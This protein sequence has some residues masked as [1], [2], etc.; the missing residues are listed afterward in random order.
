MRSCLGDD[1]R[2][3]VDAL[4]ADRRP[5]A[6]A[7]PP[8]MRPRSEAS[9]RTSS[10]SS[11]RTVSDQSVR[12]GIRGVS[13]LG[14]APDA[15]CSRSSE[16]SPGTSSRPRR[17]A[18]SCR[19]VSRGSIGGAIP[20]I[21][22]CGPTNIT[23]WWR[24]EV[25]TRPSVTCSF[26]ASA[27]WTLW[28]TAAKLDLHGNTPSW[29]PTAATAAVIWSSRVTACEAIFS[30]A[31]A[32]LIRR[33]THGIVIATSTAVSPIADR[34][35]RHGLPRPRDDAEHRQPHDPDAG[36]HAG[37][38]GGRQVEPL[39][40]RIAVERHPDDDHPPD[41]RPPPASA[42]ISQSRGLSNQANATADDAGEQHRQQLDVDAAAQ[43]PEER[44]RAEPAV[45]LLGVDRGQER[46]PR[47]DPR[48]HEPEERDRD[49]PEHD[50]HPQ[51][52]LAST[53]ATPRRR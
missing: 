30:S 24:I 46:L 51:P 45:V 49:Q 16:R 27:V 17:C 40:P 1:L 5:P 52:R 23:P 2:A 32:S 21:E 44:M 8:L 3:Q 18:I 31:L 26:H 9:R 4:V 10:G 25:P 37:Q 15:G 11:P 33:P 35:P 48:R 47:A 28:L 39:E 36:E 42:S 38:A 29:P 6:S 20:S 41:A 14:S 13:V 34:R 43:H 12:S 50:E 53:T 7:P 22:S 19:W